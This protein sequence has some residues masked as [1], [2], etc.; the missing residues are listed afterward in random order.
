MIRLCAQLRYIQQKVLPA[1]ERWLA[2]I[3]ASDQPTAPPPDPGAPGG[4]QPPHG[5]LMEA[6]VAKTNEVE[7][8]EQ[9]RAAAAEADGGLQAALAAFM[10]VLLVRA[11][12]SQYHTEVLLDRYQ[13]ALANVMASVCPR[14]LA[15]LQWLAAVAP[16][17]GCGGMGVYVKVTVTSRLFCHCDNGLLFDHSG[18]PL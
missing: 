4:L 16:T 11:S 2:L 14:L 12:V 6:V 15:L 5:A 10:H 18:D 1:D 17:R 7:V 13:H 8:E 3:P 9:L